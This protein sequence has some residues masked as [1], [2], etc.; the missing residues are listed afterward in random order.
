MNFPF[1]YEDKIKDLKIFK[2]FITTIFGKER[3]IIRNVFLKIPAFPLHYMYKEFLGL[4]ISP[5]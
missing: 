3:S 5:F 2:V 4:E 1:L